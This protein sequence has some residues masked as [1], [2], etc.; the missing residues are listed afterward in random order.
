M[1]RGVIACVAA[2]WCAGA[3]A[4]GATQ[5]ALDWLAKVS[6]ASQRLSYAGTFVYQ[7]GRTTE[8]SRITHISDATG[9]YERLETLDGPPREIVRA[10]GDVRFY[11][12][13]ERVVITD[14]AVQRRFPAWALVSPEHLIANYSARLGPVEKIAGMSARQ[15]VMEPRDGMR[16]GH[17]FWVEPAS[18][19]MLKSRT[20]DATGATVEQFVFSEV[21]VGGVIE[22]DKVRSRFAS[23]ASEWRELN[24]RGEPAKLQDSGFHCNLQVPGFRQVSVVK[25]QI[26]GSGSEAFHLVFSDGLATMSAFVETVAADK[27]P[28]VVG[29]SLAGPTRI[30]KRV[31]GGK[32][33][34]TAMGEVPAEAVRRLAESIEVRDK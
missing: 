22:R 1:M 33:L 28:P 3:A 23:T 17:A 24:V 4:A 10:N 2:L 19:L 32:Y 34:V 15:I 13:A 14:R 6:S 20:M 12:P 29:E 25:R 27:A 26:K 9:E 5:E 21:T 7:A 30:Y 11:L 16:Y 18:G 8:T 31:L